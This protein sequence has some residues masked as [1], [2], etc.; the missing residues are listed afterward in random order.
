MHE[1]HISN[2]V[3]TY[4]N[5]RHLF[6]RFMNAVVDTFRLE[7]SLNQ[8]GNQIIHTIKYRLK[9]PDHLRDKISRKWNNDDPI[10]PE[11]L[12]M[13]ITDLIGVRVLHLYQDQFPS[14]HHHIQ[15]QVDNGDWF[16]HEKPIA[17]SW[18]PESRDFFKTWGLEQKLRTHIIRAFTILLNQN[19]TQIS[20]VK[21]K[22]GHC[23]KKYGV[24]S[25][26]R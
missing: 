25:I 9:D 17:Y 13:R 8:H 15:K 18:D 2:I 19:K 6:K 7:P 1:E 14:L 21:C 20:V 4:T 3:S 23:S 22:C 12:Y 10:T 5:D 16:L 11:N 24:R 26:I